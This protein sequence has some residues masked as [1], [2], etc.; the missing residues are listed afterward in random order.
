MTT[1]NT[2]YAIVSADFKIA[3]QDQEMPDALEFDG[4]MKRLRKML[5]DEDLQVLARRTDDDFSNPDQR[6][7]AILSRSKTTGQ[8]FGVAK[9]SDYERYVS[10]DQLQGILS[11]LD[12]LDKPIRIAVLGGQSIY[13]MFTQNNL[14]DRF[15]LTYARDARLP[16]GHP[17]V[18]P[19]LGQPSTPDEF[20]NLLDLQIT[21][22]RASDDH[23]LTYYTL[24]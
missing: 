16:D 12:T 11:I 1:I 19:D 5:T 17:I 20:A 9:K 21:A 4:D 15:E 7:R 23:P 14:Y 3:D 24:S 2:G 8:V 18:N 6:P 22:R 10:A 13:T